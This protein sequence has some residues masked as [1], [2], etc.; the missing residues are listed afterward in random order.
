MIVAEE[1]EERD[2]AVMMGRSDAGWLGA[3]LSHV[4]NTWKLVGVV[5]QCGNQQYPDLWVHTKMGYC[6]PDFL[7]PMRVL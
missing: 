4:P 3:I 5:C 6:A 2:V 1:R 7:L